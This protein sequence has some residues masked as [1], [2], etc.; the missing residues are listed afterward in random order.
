[1]TRKYKESSACRMEADYAY[2]LQS[3]ASTPKIVMLKAESFKPDGWLGMLLGSKLWYN[4]YDP[5]KFEA[6]LEHMVS[7]NL[8][9][10][11]ALA[12][13]AGGG[14]RNRSASR[15]QSVDRSPSPSSASVSAAPAPVQFTA[16]GP[17]D[18][19]GR[20]VDSGGA[21]SPSF[22]GFPSLSPMPTTSHPMPMMTQMV[23][24]AAPSEQLLSTVSASI[25]SAEKGRAAAERALIASEERV[26]T[27]EQRLV[28]EQQSRLA[29]LAE[30]ME[31]LKRH[32]AALE[33]S[34]FL[35][36]DREGGA[37][38]A[39]LEQWL[40][41]INLSRYTAA[42]IREG[43]DALEFVR[44]ATDDEIAGVCKATG[45]KV[46]HAQKFTREVVAMRETQEG[47]GGVA[48]K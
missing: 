9:D 39:E 3:R 43:Y 33:A 4:V 40:G 28:D 8:K 42:L 34:N 41:G 13:P 45:M 38:A 24:A 27:L 12:K 44:A 6:E 35:G 14:Q 48:G 15:Q 2:Q 16:A 21:S 29:L 25:E 30:Q 10:C 46:P 23:H 37:E 36:S 22:N 32:N 20:S 11:T 47:G 5:S 1:M 17:R 19:S 26:K 31:A 18:S 7:K